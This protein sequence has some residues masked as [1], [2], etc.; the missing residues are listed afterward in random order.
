MKKLILFCALFAGF[1]SISQAQ[2]SIQNAYLEEFTGTWCPFCS[3]GAVRVEQTLNNNQNV[4]A[5]AIHIGNSSIPD[6]MEIPVGID[7]ASYYNPNFPQ[8][9]INRV[10]GPVGRTSWQ[11]V[12][13]SV[14]QGASVVAVSIDSVT[15][16]DA[17]RELRAKVNASFTGNESSELRFN[18]FITENNV[19]GGSAYNQYNA[20]NGTAGHPYQGAG[21]PIVG[22][23]HNHV[24]RAALGGAWGVENSLPGPVNFGSQ[25]SYWFTYTIPAGFD[26][27]EM[28]LIGVVQKFG[29]DASDREILNVEEAPVPLL[30]GLEDRPD[31]EFGV[32]EIAPNPMNESVKV[33]YILFNEGQVRMEVLNT[34]GQQVAVLG[35]GHTNAGAHSMFWNGRD[36]AGNSVDNGIYLIRLVT[37]TGQSLTRRVLVQR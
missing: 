16:D 8:A 19:T 10:G 23:V 34:L 20:D 2:F 22:F 14:T 7:I 37:E 18:M 9:L 21:N 25:A 28:H 15:Y 24:L 5:G 29:A 4:I 32:M 6:P 11:S 31:Y 27:A 17:T 33:Y 35:E 36:M 3:D 26:P 1:F 12:C 13:N 30:V